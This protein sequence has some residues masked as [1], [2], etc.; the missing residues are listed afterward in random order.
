MQ[1][2]GLHKN[3]Y[4]LY[5]YARTQEC[6]EGYRQRYQSRVDPWR[7]LKDAGV[8]DHV[9]AS[10][11]GISRSTFY[12]CRKR[13]KDLEQG[14]I[15]P[16]Q[17]PHRVHPPRWGEAEKQQVLQI[18][19][20]HPTYGKAKIAVI[21][22]R[23]HAQTLSEST[24]GRIL[25]HLKDKGLL[26][27][28]PSALRVKRKRR[29][30]KGHAQP[31]TFKKYETF[32]IGERLQIDHMTVTR[33]GLSF[34][35][36][37]AWD[38]PSKFIHAQVYSHAKSSSA[39]RFLMDLLQKVP[40][41]ILSIQ[42]DGGSEFRAEFEQAC[43]DLNIPL[44]VLPPRKPQYNGGV[45][46]GNRT[47]REE[48]YNRNTFSADT[49]SEIRTQLHQALLIYNSYRPHYHLHGLTPMQYLLN[50]QP[51]RPPSKKSH[52]T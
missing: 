24:V 15:P 42:V 44:I 37:Q 5:T 29:F 43:A 48:F 33:N 52:L 23:D 16:S 47:L 32:Q 41:P 3:I 13:L 9:I 26:Q 45:E 31:W 20:A 17:R 50:H 27:R 19:R 11:T 1:I 4:R 12:R 28:S 40:F 35:H 8:S 38:R 49:I 51:Y 46:R 34:K 25:R 14:I 7:K 6:L 36:F 39:K 18:R 21:L 30:T 2:R 22:K 10:L